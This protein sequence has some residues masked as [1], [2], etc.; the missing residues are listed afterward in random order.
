MPEFTADTAGMG[1][2]RLLEAIRHADWPV[3]FYQA[4]SSEMFGKVGDAP[5]REHAVPPAQPLRV[6]QGLR[7]LH[8]RQLPRVIRPLRQQRDPVQPR[9]AP[10]RRDV[11]H[12]QGHPRRSRR[13]SRGCRSASTGQPRRQA[14]L[15]VTRRS[16]SRRCGGCSSSPSRT[17]TS[18]PRA[19]AL[20]PRAVRGRVRPRRAGLGAIRSHD[21]K[22]FGR[23]RS[24]RSA[25]T[26]RRHIA[27]GW[28]PL[29]VRFADLIGLMLEHDL[30]RG[31]I[32]PQR[33]PGAGH[34]TEVHK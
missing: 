9:V 30:R 5:G 6:R 27:S 26:R 7:P 21:D 10:A 2:L 15:G 4:G 33:A 29:R 3:R 31:R 1:N 34:T 8:D 19:S 25:A 16:T 28:E 20:G 13:S 32:R 24:T 23:P 22:R 12:A 14:R 17:T 11:R 18:S